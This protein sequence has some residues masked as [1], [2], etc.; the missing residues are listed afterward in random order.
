MATILERKGGAEQENAADHIYQQGKAMHV[1]MTMQ[2]NTRQYNAMQSKA[3]Q[4]NTMQVTILT[5]KGKERNASQ[6]NAIYS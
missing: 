4:S 6:Y 5:N 3:S 2:S 1:Y